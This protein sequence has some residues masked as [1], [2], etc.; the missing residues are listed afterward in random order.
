MPR[1]KMHFFFKH[2]KAL[3]KFD[4]L[5]G[6]SIYFI[7]SIKHVAKCWKPL[8]GYRNLVKFFSW[9]LKKSLGFCRKTTDVV[10]FHS[11][12]DVDVISRSIIFVSHRMSV[13]IDSAAFLRFAFQKRN[14]YIC[15]HFLI[16]LHQI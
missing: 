16:N 2:F 4:E 7:Y 6:N 8:T 12:L 13:S 15:C 14:V 10:G 5:R 3:F 11:V 9:L 1:V